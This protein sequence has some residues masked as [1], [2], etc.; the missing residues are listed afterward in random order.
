MNTNRVTVQLLTAFLSLAVAAPLIVSA[1]GTGYSNGAMR[2]Q[3]LANQDNV[4]SQRRLLTRLNERCNRVTEQT[5]DLSC[6]AYLIV[7][8]ECLARQSIRQ[9]TGCPVINDLV[10]IT[11]VQEALARGESVSSAASSSSSS[12]SSTKEHGTAVKPTMADL[13]ASQRLQVRHAIQ[14]KNCS[15]KLPEIMY[16]LCIDVVG[17]NENPAPVGLTNDLGNIQQLR[18][19]AGV[20]T[21]KDRIEMS[22][23]INK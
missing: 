21:L 19:A 12:S 20:K 1:M 18:H 6:R 3:A 8:K 14:L 4:R 16:Q 2:E 10:R 9:Q 22:K 15:D 5:A 11:Q 7:Q 13:S 17:E 23:P